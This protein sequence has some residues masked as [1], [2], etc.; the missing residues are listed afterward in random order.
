MLNATKS[1]PVNGILPSLPRFNAEHAEFERLH[2]A[3]TVQLIA[4][5]SFVADM[6]VKL[7]QLYAE[8][9]TLS[10]DLEQANAKIS[11]LREDTDRNDRFAAFQESKARER[12]E[13]IEGILRRF[14]E[15]KTRLDSIDG[16]SNG[17][18]HAYTN[19]EL[20]SKKL[21]E[22]GTLQRD[23]RAVK[24]RLNISA[25]FFCGSIL[26]WMFTLAGF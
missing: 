18:Y 9:R 22:L 13:K 10:Q 8:I 7:D 20:V 26:L 23:F 14:K 5:D 15:L 2:A 17:D 16:K 11:E 21:T 25:A 1:R 6:A 24:T 4:R 3:P 19:F 12:N